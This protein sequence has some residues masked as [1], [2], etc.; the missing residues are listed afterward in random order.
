MD[1][2]KA[3]TG[4]DDFTKEEAMMVGERVWQMEHILHMRYG[5]TP[6]D[7]L[8]NVGDRWL[9]PLPDGPF[10]GFTIA[11]FLPDMVYD[12]YR[13]CGWDLATGRPTLATLKRLGME[14]FS[15]AAET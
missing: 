14:E 13:E 4:W 8:N 9:E 12:F 3:I 10:Q 2:F 15:F 6:E 1:T 7:D 5:W 11:Q